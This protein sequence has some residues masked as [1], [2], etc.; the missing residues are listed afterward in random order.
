VFLRNVITVL[1]YKKQFFEEDR[2]VSKIFINLINPYLSNEYFRCLTTQ[3][4]NRSTNLLFVHSSIYTNNV[5]LDAYIQSA[6]LKMINSQKIPKIVFKCCLDLLIAEILANTFEKKSMEIINEQ[7]KDSFKDY[8]KHTLKNF[9]LGKCKIENKVGYFSEKNIID[10]SA[11]LFEIDS[12][13]LA[14]FG[15]NAYSMRAKYANQDNVFNDNLPKVVN[16]VSKLIG[17]FCD[18]KLVKGCILKFK[19]HKFTWDCC[20]KN[21]HS[22]LNNLQK[23]LLFGKN[24][25]IS[26]DF[27]NI[28]PGDELFEKR[29]DDLMKAKFSTEQIDLY[30]EFVRTIKLENIEKIIK[31][32]KSNIKDSIRRLSPNCEIFENV[33]ENSHNFYLICMSY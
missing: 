24:I 22:A 10:Y 12:F 2:V 28:I 16:Q 6:Y 23:C 9:C 33:S 31:I 21:K 5:E 8:L 1:Q 26:F 30:K 15:K 13:S 14:F 19:K 29:L 4:A 11:K 27:F 3:I 25:I 17:N 20:R 7:Q 18:F 32:I